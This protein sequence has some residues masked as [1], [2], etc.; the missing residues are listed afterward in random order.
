M[1]TRLIIFVA[2]LFMMSSLSSCYLEVEVDEPFVDVAGVREYETK[3]VIYQEFQNGQ[4]V[5]EEAVYNAWLDIDLWNNGGLRARN[6][7]VEVVIIDEFG[8]Q[9]SFINTHDVRPGETITISYD[10]GFDFTNDYIDY[11]VYVYW[12]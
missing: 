12:D 8:E 9:S 6:V 2:I 3:D 7:Q 1:K 11:E 5:Y 10:T 4:L